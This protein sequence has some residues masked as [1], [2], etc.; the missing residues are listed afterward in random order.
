M[1]ESR[2]ADSVNEA[3]S[4]RKESVLWIMVLS[5]VVLA[6]GL[7]AAALIL[8][9]PRVDAALLMAE[10]PILPGLYLSQEMHGD[11]QEG[12]A[13]CPRYGEVGPGA[14]YAVN[15]DNGPS[16]GAYR[17]CKDLVWTS[18]MTVGY[19]GSKG[20]TVVGY[21]STLSPPIGEMD[22]AAFTYW[23]RHYIVDGLSYMHSD[24]SSYELT[25]DL[26]SGL[27]IGMVLHVGGISLPLPHAQFST[28]EAKYAWQ[29]R[30]NP[31]WKDGQGLEVVLSHNP[32]V[33][34]E[35]ELVW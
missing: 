33:S 29:L 14:G 30:G 16:T 11:T 27:P 19:Q 21:D 15:P 35:P 2:E 20:N 26:D 6:F 9:T 34:T 5:P 13:D 1:R 28:K 24:D 3:E 23:K 12:A 7:V 25:L 22:D 8:G 31:A 10:G 4:K 18:T 32:S 17:E